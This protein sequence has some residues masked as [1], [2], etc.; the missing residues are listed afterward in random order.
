MLLIAWAVLVFPAECKLKSNADTDNK[1]SLKSVYVHICKINYGAY[2][3]I[4]SML[5]RG[6]EERKKLL[7]GI[8]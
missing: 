5:K 2:T 3:T 6:G 4:S 1:N 7:P 8:S